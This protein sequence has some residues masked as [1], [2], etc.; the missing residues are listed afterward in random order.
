M[1]CRIGSGRCCVSIRAAKLGKNFGPNGYEYGVEMN[2]RSVLLAATAL[3]PLCPG[4]SLAACSAA[5]NNLISNCSFESLNNR[6]RNQ[7][8]EGWSPDFN[9]ANPTTQF[10]T[11]GRANYTG[12]YG[13]MFGNFGRTSSLSQTLSTRSGADY[14]LKFW[15]RNSTAG[16][17]TNQTFVVT[18][19]NQ[20]LYA[21]AGTQIG[22][23]TQITTRYRATSGTTVL[24]FEGRN[25]P[26]EYQLDEVEWLGRTW[27]ETGQAAGKHAAPVGRAL[28]RIAANAGLTNQLATLSMLDD[29]G[30]YRAMKQM[31][32]TVLTPQ[33]NVT[34]AS[35]TPSLSAINAH[36]TAQLEHSGSA[37]NRG[38]AAGDGFQQGALWGQMLGGYSALKTSGTVDGFAANTV[39]IVLG[40]DLYAGKEVVAGLAFDWIRVNA[41]GKGDAA[42]NKTVTDS[43]LLN[44]YGTWQP[45]GTNSFLQGVVSVGLNKYDQN[46]QIDFLG[47]TASAEYDGLQLLGKLTAGHDFPLNG[48]NNG[49]TVTPL[50][51]LQV[52]RVQNNGYT[53]TGS[54][55]AQS[56]EKQGF[57]AV[58]SVIG[59][60]VSQDFTTAAGLLKADLQLGWLHDYNRT[61]LTTNSTLA[62]VSYSVET[63]RLPTNGAL[64][65]VGA[66][67]QQS[68]DV[69]LRAE[70]DGDIRS[71]YS[72]HTGLLKIRQAF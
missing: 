35:Y 37:A 6:N 60:R 21:T 25:D 49:L 46:R 69:S 19:N 59:G 26:F 7:N 41:R 34:G 44:G 36:Q 11:I 40:A 5:A 57:N 10:G 55:V 70:Y 9:N 3:V 16:T 29:S 38:A 72:S 18:A 47:E 8:F 23:W 2:I 32:A 48:L 13:V 4:V 71:G 28:D 54:S 15:L 53:E 14:T 20:V 39:G 43:F 31:S 63:A 50:A 45:S 66:T 61:P 30:Q 33:V 65:A 24:K 68:D 62:G 64:I 22:T 51:S 52:S 42:G 67:L 17:S 12:N 56:V 27:S 58:E 1:R